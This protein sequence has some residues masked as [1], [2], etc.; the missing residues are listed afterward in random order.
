MVTFPDSGI[1][2]SIRLNAS[3]ADGADMRRLLY[4][5]HDLI[6]AA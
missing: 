4:E 5:V 3:S 6:N 2:M 1:S